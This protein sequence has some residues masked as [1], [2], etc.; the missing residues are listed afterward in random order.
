MSIDDF[1]YLATTEQEEIKQKNT[2]LK[3]FQWFFLT[4]LLMFVI[5]IALFV[6]LVFIYITVQY[7]QVIVILFLFIVCGMWSANMMGFLK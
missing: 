6:L 3:I 2:G 5:S 1:D 4:I 7:P